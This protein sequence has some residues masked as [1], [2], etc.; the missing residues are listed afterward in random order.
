M[1]KLPLTFF[2]VGLSFG[3]GPCLA[4]CGPLLISY[5]AGSGKNVPG[6]IAAYF[7]FSLPRLVIYAILSLV[8]YGCGVM[9]T[10]ISMAPVMKY[11]TIGAGIIFISIGF[12]I[13]TR[14]QYLHRTCAFFQEKFISQDKKTLVLLGIFMGILPCAPL[15]SVLSYIGFIAKSWQQCLVYGVSFGLGTLLSPLLL[16]TALGGLIPSII[17]DNS[18]I[19][20][21]MDIVCGFVIVI[22]GVLLIWRIF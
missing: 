16:L 19:R 4:S 13:A 3:A 6:S 8:I 11:V 15:I 20:K 21:A 5:V 12:L 7:L 9:M 2:L 22:L 1:F 10:Q 17:K 18:V 14:N